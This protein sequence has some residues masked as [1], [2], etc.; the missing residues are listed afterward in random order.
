MLHVAR[1]SKSSE[2]ANMLKSTR[3]SFIFRCFGKC[4]VLACWAL[5]AGA[6]SASVH[7]AER[8]AER[9]RPA[10]SSAA[11]TYQQTN[12]SGSILNVEDSGAGSHLKVEG[13]AMAAPSLGQVT[14]GVQTKREDDVLATPG[15]L[16]ASFAMLIL[17]VLRRLSS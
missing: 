11:S 13:S 4:S 2:V 8:L 6:L 7:A 17:M 12:F 15:V 1:H 9:P 16:L 5:V 10:A 3:P 14:A